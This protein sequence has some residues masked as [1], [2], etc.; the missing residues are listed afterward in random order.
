MNLENIKVGKSL[1][2]EK[3]G[4]PLPEESFIELINIV[5]TCYKSMGINI[6][7]MRM[8]Y[9]RFLNKN[10]VLAIKLLEESDYERNNYMFVG[11]SPHNYNDKIHCDVFIHADAKCAQE[12]MEMSRR[13]SRNIVSFF[14]KTEQELEENG[15]SDMEFSVTIPLTEDQKNQDSAPTKKETGFK[16]FAKLFGIN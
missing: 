10:S 2:L 13:I 5:K 14:E 16:R 1:S 7:K 11:C 4:N 15:M 12:A 8:E 9:H 6:D 3:V